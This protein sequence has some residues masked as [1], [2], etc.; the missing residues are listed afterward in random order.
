MLEER[1]K[2]KGTSASIESCKERPSITARPPENPFP[3]GWSRTATTDFSCRAFRLSLSPFFLCPLVGP[4]GPMGDKWL[5]DQTL[6]Q[7]FCKSRQKLACT[8][9]KKRRY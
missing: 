7:D 9:Q 3:Q 2:E 4:L 8:A 5:T 6:S 1:K